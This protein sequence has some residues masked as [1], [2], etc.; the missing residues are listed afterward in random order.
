MNKEWNEVAESLHKV[1]QAKKY[2]DQQEKA[3]LEKLKELSGGTSASG[4]V[5]ELKMVIRPGTI[6]YARIPELYGVC[7]DNYRKAP[8]TNWL[9]QEK[10]TLPDAIPALEA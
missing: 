7:L 10:I 9:L 3:Y 2:Y 8:V 4:D 6:E 1:K 5:F